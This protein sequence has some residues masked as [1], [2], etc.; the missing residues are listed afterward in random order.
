MP[1]D[2]ASWMDSV[3]GDTKLSELSIPGTH[4]SASRYIDP[5]G[6]TDPGT[7]PRL[8]TQTDSIREQLDSG[9]RFLD[10]RV[11]YTDN[12]FRLYHESVSLNLN[13]GPVRDICSGFLQ[14][15]PRETIIMSLKIEEMAPTSGNDEKG[16]FQG[17]FRQ[18][19]EESP[20]LWYLKNTIPTLRQARGKIVLFRRFALDK[21]AT[22]T[23]GINAFN[24]FPNDGTGMIDTP[25]KL[26]I[27][28]KFGQ[29]GAEDTKDAKWRAVVNLLDDASKADSD[30]DTLYL[31]FGSAAGVA[32]VDFPL[33]VANFI[34]PN[35]LT[36]FGNHATGRFGIV[37][38]DFQTIELNRLVIRTNGLVV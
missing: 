23:V 2:L 17:R 21:D 32:P 36:Y 38:M 31:N 24:G 10:I 18:Y 27:Q 26:K 11:G 28:D 34:N 29:T 9:I 4:D 3:G 20:K 25:A 12:V 14:S 37:A 7:S 19:V 13:F 35:F 16:T 15:H 33:S 1:L 30:Q 8:T 22:A 6:R 5:R